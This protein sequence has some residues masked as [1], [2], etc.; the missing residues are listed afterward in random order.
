MFCLICK[1]STELKQEG[2]I[3]TKQDLYELHIT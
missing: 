2:N 1:T 3:Q